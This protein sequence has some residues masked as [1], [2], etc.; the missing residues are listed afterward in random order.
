MRKKDLNPQ[1]FKF[2]N[3][4]QQNQQPVS[5]VEMLKCTQLVGEKW[6]KKSDTNV[7][8]ALA[9]LNWCIVQLTQFP[10]TKQPSKNEQ[11]KNP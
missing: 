3:R 11:R 4:Q 8:D 2:V 1:P 9:Y 10:L 6:N 7:L 5:T